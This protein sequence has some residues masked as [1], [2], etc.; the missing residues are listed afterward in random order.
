MLSFFIVSLVIAQQPYAYRSEAAAISERPQYV[1]TANATAPTPKMK[2]ARASSPVQPLPR[3]ESLRDNLR[4]K[5]QIAGSGKSVGIK[6][7]DLI[8]LPGAP[9]QPEVKPPP[10]SFPPVVKKEEKASL[11][12]DSETVFFGFD[13]S[14]LRDSEKAKLDLLDKS[15]AYKIT[16]Y[17]CDIGTKVYN[18]AL[19]LRRAKA[20]AA[21]MGVHSVTEGRGK[22]CY[23]DLKNRP[24]NR[25]VEIKRLEATEGLGASGLTGR[26]RDEGEMF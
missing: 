6:E 12:K 5:S 1:L 19:A 7:K 17:T 4:D 20:V 24:R 10:L 3:K 23:V 9:V 15:A 26:Q 8:R 25:R 18:D 22:C 11:M 21:Y 16:G 14:F 13:S 2:I